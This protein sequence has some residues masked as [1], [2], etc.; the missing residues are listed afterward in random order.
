MYDYIIAGAGCSG[1]SLLHYILQVPNLKEKKI[2]LI[3][4]EWKTQNDRTWCF[5]EAGVGDFEQLVCKKWDILTF[6]R[7]NVHLDLNINPYHYKMIQGIDFYEFIQKEIAQ[8]P[9]ITFLAANIEKITETENTAE[10]ITDKGVFS[11]EI[12]FS[13]VLNYQENPRKHNAVAQHFKGWLIE[14]GEERFE[15]NKATFM[16]FSIPQ[17]NETRFVY[18]L[19]RDKRTALVEY[20][21]FS[22]Q[23]ISSEEYDKLIQYY[24]KTHLQITDYQILHTE[25]GVIP[26]TNYPFHT[27][28][29]KRI[30]YIGTAGGQ[31]KASSG[32]AFQRIQKAMKKVAEQLEKGEMPRK[33]QDFRF[34]KYA[35]FDTLLLNVML[36][37]RFPSDKIFH[38]LFK[39]NPP[40]RVLA[41]LN[42]ETT[43]IEDLKIMNSVPSM[44]FIRAI[45]DEV[46]KKMGI[47]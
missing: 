23:L 30:F 14:V 40:Q 20:T 15:E 13:S 29:K 41:F 38:F 3:D 27:H 34:Q 32:F 8:F 17:E 2:L 6:K 5:W 35:W 11:A 4:K 28:D 21:V 26:M 37:H 7:Q 39:N 12:V 24:L 16:D 33:K 19:P 45:F 42:E 36:N 44:P 46:R 22:N 10:V 9:N 1:L 31:V 18:V 47:K 25:M 43:I